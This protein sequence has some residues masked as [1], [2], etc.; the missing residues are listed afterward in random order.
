MVTAKRKLIRNREKLYPFLID[1]LE[2][3]NGWTD[4]LKLHMRK[5]QFG[6]CVRLIETHLKYWRPSPIEDKEGCMMINVPLLVQLQRAL[7]LAAI[8]SEE[9][10]HLSVKLDVTLEGV[11]AT[12]AELSSRLI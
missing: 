5:E 1:I 4:L 6:E 3:Q 8:E 9:L 2:S 7:K 12:L 10:S 11:K